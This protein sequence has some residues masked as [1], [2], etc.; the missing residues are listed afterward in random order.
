MDEQIKNKKQPYG[1]EKGIAGLFTDILGCQK[2]GL[3]INYCLEHSMQKEWLTPNPDY[4]KT[5]PKDNHN[6]FQEKDY[7]EGTPE[8]EIAWMQD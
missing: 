3:D 5:K 8:K 2:K 1:S 4:F 7:G 6:G